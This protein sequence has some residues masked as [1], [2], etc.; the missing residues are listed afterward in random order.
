MNQEILEIL[1]RRGA[2]IITDHETFSEVMHTFRLKRPPT[3]G[4]KIAFFNENVVMKPLTGYTKLL[5][6]SANIYV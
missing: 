4:V 5:K 1:N 2:V 3:S 6:E